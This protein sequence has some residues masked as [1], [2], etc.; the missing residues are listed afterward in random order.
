MLTARLPILHVSATRYQ[1][2]WGM[3]PQ[4]NKFEQI[5]RDGR[6]MSIV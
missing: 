3:G 5:S 4:V 1:Y 2:Q 6:Q